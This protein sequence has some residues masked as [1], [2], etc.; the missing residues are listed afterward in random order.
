ML[1]LSVAELFWELYGE[2]TY[3]VTD[4]ADRFSLSSHS[5]ILLHP[6]QRELAFAI[7]D[8]RWTEGFLK[9]RHLLSP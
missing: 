2:S 6:L 5:S 7:A 9:P 8:I 4:D 3:E 1:S